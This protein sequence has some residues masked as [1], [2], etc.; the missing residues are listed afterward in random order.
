MLHRVG[1]YARV[2]TRDQNPEGQIMELRKFAKRRGFR[3]Y[4][5]YVDHVTGNMERRRR[6]NTTKDAAFQQL[7]ADAR[8]RKFDAVLVWRFDRFAR[9][10]TGLIEGLKEFQA[11]G[12]DFISQTEEVD[13]TTAM[14]RLFF[15]IVGA[16]AEFER[17]L[18]VER[19]NA[20]LA[21]ARENGVVFGRPRDPAIDAKVLQLAKKDPKPSLSA[22]G[23]E[24]GRSLW[25]VRKILIRAGVYQ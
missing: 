2:S 6:E 5:E 25:G 16:F 3:I 1:I 20:G 23:K 13:T 15:H 24:V 7:M 9:S 12:V 17:E 8:Q 10:I 11:L 21:N 4:K 22:I 14:G 18:I 19:V